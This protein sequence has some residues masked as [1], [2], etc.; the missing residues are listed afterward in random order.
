MA[1]YTITMVSLATPVPTAASG[2]ANQQPWSAG[3]S[4]FSLASATVSKVVINDDDGR[5]DTLIYA[6]TETDQKLANDTVFGTGS[7]ATT[8]PAGSLITNSVYTLIRDSA[9]QEFY[10]LFPRTGAVGTSGTLVGGKTSVFILPKPVTNASGV[11]VFPTFDPSSTFR[12]IGLH[13]PSSTNHSFA[14]EP[15]TVTCFAKGTLIQ[16]GSG[17]KR[18]EDLRPGDMIVTRDHGLQRLDWIGS[19]YLDTERL[20]LQPNLRP[21]MIRKGAL[22]PNAPA[23]DLV[24]SPQHRVMVRSRIV[25]RMF[26]TDEIL[27]A[28]KHLVGLPGIE[29]LNP[30]IGIT[31]YHLLFSRHEIVRSDGAWSESLFTGPQALQSVSDAARR[32]IFVLFPQLRDPAHV[33]TGARRLLNGREGRKLAERHAKNAVCLVG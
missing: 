27:V 32:E 1:Q 19:T 29:I 22:G 33:V 26:D 28:A 7:H 21:I 13:S 10:A 17:E 31:Y 23:R 12:V 3:G 14:Y 5:F 9:G 8:L 20:D 6:K 18:I 25:Q 2:T 24:V 30:A 16:T 11:Q 15:V 4:Q